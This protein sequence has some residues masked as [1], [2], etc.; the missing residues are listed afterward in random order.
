MREKTKNKGRRMESFS[1]GRGIPTFTVEEEIRIDLNKQGKVE[2]GTPVSQSGKPGDLMR[3]RE[4]EVEGEHQG[5]G[6]EDALEAQLRLDLPLAVWF[7][8]AAFR[9]QGRGLEKADWVRKSDTVH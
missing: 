7:C 5:R 1:M 2:E 3:E 4:P 9:S 6:D 8:S